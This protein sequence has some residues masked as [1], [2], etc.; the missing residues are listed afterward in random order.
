LNG[1]E[2]FVH[3]FIKN[4]QTTKLCP[5]Y[6]KW[7]NKEINEALFTQSYSRPNIVGDVMGKSSRTTT[8]RY[9]EELVKAKILS[10]KKEGTGIFYLNDDLIR[11]PEG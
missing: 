1:K 4:E 11:I 3:I 5:S 6:I 10:P 7:Y 9:I 2:L 8:S